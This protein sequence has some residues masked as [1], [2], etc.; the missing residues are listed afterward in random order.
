MSVNEK[1]PAP[2]Q[3]DAEECNCHFCPNLWDKDETQSDY[4]PGEAIHLPPDGTAVH[5]ERCLTTG[6]A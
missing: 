3:T 4:V 6:N 1:E 2:I 5:D